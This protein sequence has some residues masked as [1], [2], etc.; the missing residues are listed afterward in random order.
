MLPVA[1]RRQG[2]VTEERGLRVAAVRAAV[3]PLT[4]IIA[5]GLGVGAVALARPTPRLERPTRAR[6]RAAFSSVPGAALET[7]CR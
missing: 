5:V 2:V 4:Q 3:P 1:L 6:A 7:G